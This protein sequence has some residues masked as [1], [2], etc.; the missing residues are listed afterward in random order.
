M[1][2]EPL[3]NKAIK[4][5]SASYV[6]CSVASLP[7][8]IDRIRPIMFSSY[9][10]DCLH[11]TFFVMDPW[12]L[13][14]RGFSIQK[15]ILN[16]EIII[17]FKHSKFFNIVVSFQFIN[18]ITLFMENKLNNVKKSDFGQQIFISIFAIL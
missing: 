13:T 1:L 2:L 15:E 17:F 8:H 10:F 3:K 7:P 12:P 18:G 16:F 14:K 11:R 9:Y 6:S 4:G 5:D